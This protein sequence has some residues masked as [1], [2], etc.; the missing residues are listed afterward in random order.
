MSM[1]TSTMSSPASDE[2][3]QGL[4][5]IIFASAAGTMIEWY[6]FYIFGSLA[7]TI[8]PLFYP[9]TPDATKE[10]QKAKLAKRLAHIDR[11]LAKQPYLMGQN[12]TVADAYLHTILNWSH[13]LKVDVAPFP[14]IVEYQKRIAARPAVV[15]AHNAE[16]QAKAGAAA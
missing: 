8:S 15:K 12:F 13:T 11:I 10:T 7:V 14:A 5:R 16:H 2:G 1:R 4:P 3:G 9:D 6:D